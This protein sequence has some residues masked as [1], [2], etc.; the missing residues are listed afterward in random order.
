M[1]FLLR[2][3][4]R[5][6][7]FSG[8]AV[9]F[10]LAGWAGSSAYVA[11]R[12]TRRA[13]PVFAEPVPAVT[14]ASWE[15]VK[16]TTQDG[17][18]IGAWHSSGEPD[19]PVIVLL[20]GNGASRGVT[21][22][23]AKCLASAGYSLLAVSLRGH[24]DSEGE[25]NDFGRS[26][27]ADVIAAVDYLERVQPGVPIVIQGSSLGAAAALFAADRLQSRAAGY[28][29]ECPYTDIYTAVRNRT[30]QN[31]PPLADQMAYAGLVLMAPLVLEDPE[32]I[33]PLQHAQN[34]PP[35]VPVLIMAG[36]QDHH[37]TVAEAEQ[38][39]QAIG[40]N[41]HL[42]LINSGEHGKLQACDPKGYERCLLSFLW[43]LEIN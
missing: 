12:L 3:T 13:Q 17:F 2:I 43:E 24:G 42:T 37:A 38:L 18:S 33:S 39:Q 8:L 16:L 11:Y 20:H 36:E 23:V 28:V 15:P 35:E 22:P 31:L 5:R 27:A 40:P 7:A 32:S 29:L 10:L 34:F 21:L 26:A 25:T 30:R 4:R 6:W 41:C 14:W 1:R 19:K 9:V